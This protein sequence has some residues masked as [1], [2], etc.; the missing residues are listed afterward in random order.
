LGSG[1][2][3]MDVPPIP[4]TTPP[5]VESWLSPYISFREEPVQAGVPNQICIE[6][7]NPL[8]VSKTVTL[9]YNVA[10][11]GAGIDFTPVATRTVE[12]PPESI[13]KYCVD[14]TPAEA[15]H[16]CV[17]VEV[18][19][20]GWQS[21]VAQ[22]NVDVVAG[23]WRPE[24]TIPFLLRNPDLFTHRVD[25]DIRMWGIDPKLFRPIIRI[26]KPGG[27]DPVPVMINAG[28]ELELEIAFIA[29]NATAAALGSNEAVAMT[30]FGDVQR[31]DVGVTMDGKE[32]SGLSAIFATESG[33]NVFLPL[34]LK[35]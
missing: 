23:G 30:T 28:Q 27:G 19:L 29:L 35:E 34:M 4:V 24:I 31:V 21:Q 1:L 17:A 10:Q 11:F 12:L 5:G 22:R 26:P 33:G 3:K 15:V 9:V 25:F 2:R 7:Q 14:W 18:Q 32:V 8:P 20:V 6:L 13:D 16:Y